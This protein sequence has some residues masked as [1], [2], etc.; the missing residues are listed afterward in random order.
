[1]NTDILGYAD[2]SVNIYEKNKD[3]ETEKMQGY[4]DYLAGKGESGSK[5]NLLKLADVAATTENSIS[6]EVVNNRINVYGPNRQSYYGPSGS[7]GNSNRIV[8]IPCTINL[9]KGVA[10]EISLE[11]MDSGIEDSFGILYS[12]KYSGEIYLPGIDDSRISYSGAE[13]LKEFICDKDVNVNY[14]VFSVKSMGDDWRYDGEVGSWYTFYAAN[15]KISIV[16]K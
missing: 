14:I 9:K 8:Q 3:N 4:E 10:Y 5:E 11:Q 16:E 12:S 6:V 15:F 7:N 1:M 2:R 13:S